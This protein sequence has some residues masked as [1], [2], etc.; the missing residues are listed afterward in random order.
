MLWALRR[1]E[2][3]LVRKGNLALARQSG[4]QLRSGRIHAGSSND[5]RPKA[6]VRSETA[7]AARPARFRRFWTSAFARFDGGSPVSS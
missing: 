3:W 4:A 6:V 5:A 2:P 1:I 7:Q